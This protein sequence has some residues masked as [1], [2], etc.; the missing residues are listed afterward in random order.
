MNITC[1]IP[2]R[3]GSKGIPFKNLKEIAGHPLIAH[4]IMQARNARGVNRVYV[5]TDDPGIAG[6]AETYGA[7]TISRPDEISGDSASSESALLHALEVIERESP[8]P[9][10]LVVFLQCTSPLREA[11]DIDKAIGQLISE[12]ADSLL[13]VTPSHRFLWERSGATPRSINYDYR[14][15]KRRQELPPQFVENG[16]IYIFKPWVLKRLHNRL[17]GAISLYC[18]KEESNYEIDSLLDFEIVEF[19]LA[20]R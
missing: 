7:L 19:L 3:G 12:D 4:S 17:G 13:S 15:R 11:D 5:S 18:M 2:A 1:I 10:D 8:L 20:R 14:D 16:S 6:L 9:P